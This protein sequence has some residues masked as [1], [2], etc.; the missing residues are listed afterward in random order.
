MKNAIFKLLLVLVTANLFSQ[1][2][3]NT[4]SPETT[5]EVA[6]KADDINHYDGILPPR[7]TG[8]QLSRKTYT[9]SKKGAVIFI[10]VPATNLSGQVINIKEAGLYYFDGNIWQ[11][12]S[13]EKDPT[14]Y[15]IQL[16]LDPDSTE[17]LSATSNWFPPAN[18]WGN[19]N[20]YLTSFKKYTIGTKNFGG[21]NG[22]I[23]FRKI[24]G[25]INVHFQMYR[26]PNVPITGSAFINL[27]DLYR[28][29]GYF[30]SQ[31]VL[32]HTE[33][34]TQYFP[35]LLE[36]FSL[37][38]PQTSLNAMSTIYYT[39]GDVQGYSYWKRPSGS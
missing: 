27:E 22:V 8:D 21:L 17:A 1:V 25:A 18:T 33:N 23:I 11:A 37:Q 7:I 12:F 4:A 6:G 15:Y 39:Y 3:I 38:I 10:T 14:E 5:F 31:I 28:D 29:L 34:S 2:G 35:A 19:T 24:Q 36:N 32:L 26:S 20:A 9:L 30:P 16:V 13:K